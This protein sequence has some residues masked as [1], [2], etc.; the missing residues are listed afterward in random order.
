MDDGAGLVAPIDDHDTE[1]AYQVMGGVNYNLAEDLA[2]GLEYRFFEAERYH[3][4]D[5]VGGNINPE[6]NSHSF[7]LTVTLGF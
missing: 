7:M 4:Q 1:F 2:L 6:Y 3:L 5:S